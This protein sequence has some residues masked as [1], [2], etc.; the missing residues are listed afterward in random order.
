MAVCLG[1][2]L[3]LGRPPRLV[4]VPV[5]FIE[6]WIDNAV[7]LLWIEDNLELYYGLM[8][9]FIDWL[10]QNWVQNPMEYFSFTQF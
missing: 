10:M 4:V 1:R 2:Q 6:E 7:F 9:A 5:K 8:L 3:K